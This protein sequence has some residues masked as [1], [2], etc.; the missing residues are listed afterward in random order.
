MRKKTIQILFMLALCTGS[1]A[2]ELYVFFPTEIRAQAVQKKLEESCPGISVVVFGRYKDFEAKCLSDNP[3][4]ILVTPAIIK[5]IPGYSI[6]KEGYNDNDKEESY[7][8]VS[9]NSPIKPED[10]SKTVISAV[11]L[12]GRKETDAFYRRFFPT[13]PTFKCVSKVEDLLPALTF[14][15]AS[16]ILI[17][18]SY[19][20]YFRNTSKLN[21]VVTRLPDAKAGIVALGVKE[22]SKSVKIVK[23]IHNLKPDVSSIFRVNSWK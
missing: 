20:A 9:I 14:N 15:L 21:F 17:P 4:A 18:K 6:K 8:I 12:M 3:D 10:F 23:A 1:S 22:K 7:V 13:P 11:D 16:G 5:Q 2:E 19:V